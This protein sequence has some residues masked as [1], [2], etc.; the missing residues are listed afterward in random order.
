MSSADGFQM[1]NRRTQLCLLFEN[2]KKIDFESDFTFFSTS[3]KNSSFS[4]KKVS[5]FKNDKLCQR[6]SQLS[7]NNVIYDLLLPRLEEML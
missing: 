6:N 4:V 1:K 7:K 5:N 2:K 3:L